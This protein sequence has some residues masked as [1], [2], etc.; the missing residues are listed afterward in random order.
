VSLSVPHQPKGQRFTLA[1]R[2][3]AIVVLG[4]KFH[5]RVADDSVGVDVDEGLVEVRR[6]WRSIRVGSGESWTSPSVRRAAPAPAPRTGGPP[7]VPSPPVALASAAAPVPAVAEPVAAD[8]PATG[9]RPT[10][11]MDRF[12]EARM[13]LG[14]GR[15]EAALDILAALARGVG[16]AAEN[17]AYEIGR[18]HADHL[19]RPR[20]AITAW[21]RYRQ[22]FPRGLLRVEADISILET[23]AKIGDIDDALAEADAFVQRHPDSERRDEVVRIA[24]RLRAARGQ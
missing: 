1:A 10:V 12:A 18:V 6:G 7:A 9:P 21:R 4:T 2:G 3:Y 8:G 14:E 24:D 5:V 23:L 19:L 22:R 15:P 13:A 16:P 11:A 20:N 17:A